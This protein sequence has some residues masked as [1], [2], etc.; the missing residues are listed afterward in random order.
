M[1]E[2]V[3]Q[4]LDPLEKF[5]IITPVEYSEWAAPIVVVRKANGSILICGDYSPGLNAALQPNQYPLCLPDDIFAKLASCGNGWTVPKVYHTHRD[6]YSYNHLLPGVKIALGALKQL[7]DTMLAVLQCTCGHLDD[8][9]V[10]GKTEEYHDRNLRAVLKRIQDFGF[11][12]R[13][14]KCTLSK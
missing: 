9:I 8:I 6:P 10:G 4:E 7:I 12:V 5:N 1:Y 13:V 14:E 3:D 2:A 11:T